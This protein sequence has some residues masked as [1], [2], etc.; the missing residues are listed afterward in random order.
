M[1][2]IIKEIKQIIPAVDW[3]AEFS[4]KDAPAEYVRVIVWASVICE[5][6]GESYPTIVGYTDAGGYLD[7]AEEC[8]NLVGYQHKEDIEII[9]EK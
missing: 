3:F 4:Y 9:K 6:N 7:V 8:S 1:S 5:D 2:I